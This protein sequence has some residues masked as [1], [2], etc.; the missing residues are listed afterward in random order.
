MKLNRPTRTWNDHDLNGRLHP[1][2]TAVDA[3]NESAAPLYGTLDV[4]ADVPA[5]DPV[6]D[7]EP[8]GGAAP[9]AA[10]FADA[11]SEAAADA[12]P[13]YWQPAV[14]LEAQTQDRA[15]APVEP[16]TDVR[17]PAPA[18]PWTPEV[19]TLRGGDAE[20]A[21]HLSVVDADPFAPL[22]DRLID[23]RDGIADLLGAALDAVASARDEAA[24]RRAAAQAEAAAIVAAAHDEAARIRAEAL[25]EVEVAQRRLAA[26]TAEVD[27]LAAHLRRTA[28]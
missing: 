24:N 16:R 21:R 18:E 20:V 28:P 10:Y 13:Q 19:P 1:E 14:S 8:E 3:P 5:D 7:G 17:P 6:D 22:L 25:V 4:F 9:V 15:Q 2:R 11:P 27:G 12:V 26:F 23:S